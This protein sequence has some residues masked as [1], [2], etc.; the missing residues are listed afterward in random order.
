M[1]LS[2]P[3]QHEALAS[4]VPRFA[5]FKPQPKT[6]LSSIDG[7]KL[8]PVHRPRQKRH[9]YRTHQHDGR[10]PPSDGA[11]RP[12]NVKAEDVHATY[13][14][15]RIAEDKQFVVDKKGDS[16]NITYGSLHQYSVPSFSRWGRGRVLGTAVSARIDCELSSGKHTVVQTHREDRSAQWRKTIWRGAVPRHETR[17]R[18]RQQSPEDD[19]DADFIPLKPRKRRRI[20]DADSD[21][22]GN[23]GHYRSIDGKAKA[24]TSEDDSDTEAS[25]VLHSENE[26]RSRGVELSRLV[27]REPHNGQAWLDL[28]NH[29]DVEQAGRQ[30]GVRP[31]LAE[32]QSLADIKTAM[33]AKALQ[34]V[35]DPHYR[36]E[37]LTRSMLE[38]AHTV[39]AP[40][41]QKRWKT[42]LRENLAMVRLWLPYLDLLQTSFS[43]FQFDDLREAFVQCLRVLKEGRSRR[44]GTGYSTTEAYLLLRMTV[45]FRG[46]GFIEQAIAMWQAL[47]E[48]NFLGPAADEGLGALLERFE[49]FWE[50]EVPRVGEGGAR[51]WADFSPDIENQHFQDAAETEAADGSPAIDM[52][53]WFNTERSFSNRKRMPGRSLDRESDDPYRVVL[54]SD[55]KDFVVEVPTLGRELLLHA[56]LAFCGLPPMSSLP[57]G[58]EAWWNDPFIPSTSP[59][60]VRKAE[61]DL[62]ASKGTA[63]SGTHSGFLGNEQSGAMAFGKPN[64]RVSSDS[65][66]ADP[67]KWFS[68]TAP[69]ISKN[70]GGDDR[71]PA[72]WVR[73]AVRTLVDRDIGGEDLAEAL[74]AMEVRLYPE[75]VRKTAKVLLKRR[76]S[77]LRL[78]NAYA[79]IE[80]RLGNA[81]GG[82]KVLSMATT[83]RT[84][85]NGGVLLWRTWVLQALFTGR[86]RDALDRILALAA[87]DQKLLHGRSDTAG[88]ETILR[89]QTQLIAARDKCQQQGNLS[90]AA[91]FIDCLIVLSYLSSDTPLEAA[92]SIFRSNIGLLQADSSNVRSVRELRHQFFAQLLYHHLMHH[93]QF[94]PSLVRDYLT[95]SIGLYPENTIFLS[96]FAWHE[97]RY[98][99]DDRVRSIVQTNLHSAASGTKARQES[100]VLLLFAI[101]TELSRAVTL[102]SNMHSIRSA[103]ERAVESNAAKHSPA[104][105]MWYFD[106][107]LSRS[108]GS[109]AKAIFYRAIRAC[110]WAKELYLLP[111]EGLAD[112]MDDREL[113]GC[114]QSMVDK[115]LRVHAPLALST[116]G[117]SKA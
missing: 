52:K 98:R 38:S 67:M 7:P 45:C 4:N 54:C 113:Q 36:E 77:S 65:L 34:R 61:G 40:V 75:Q 62:A 116:E 23:A 27:E 24:V 44:A 76:P 53:A 49:E 90:S 33:I 16:D 82:E 9:G 87:N 51:G 21:E 80:Y 12:S 10:E 14:V 95:D 46:A 109:K 84:P 107:E 15:S 57:E 105:W 8:D 100:F 32:R 20:G 31:T 43:T 50:S 96:L 42:L 112:I 5:S 64:F 30:S 79:L 106:F 101:H 69:T 114:Y 6:S 88:P 35:Q 71:V 60:N 41:L 81:A 117:R 111:A 11:P 97:A 2:Y 94:R 102:G 85:E 3:H 99:I 108:E 19:R 89:A 17:V 66:F 103:F 18:A 28:I 25:A 48:I 29:Q 58:S 73:R 72:D 56:F 74:L 110:P 63:A 59:F 13:D 93:A 115:E 70:G 91:L 92:L 86:Q 78:Y 1:T 47:L 37:L 55:I 22:S 26:T 83:M 68:P 39:D 104:L